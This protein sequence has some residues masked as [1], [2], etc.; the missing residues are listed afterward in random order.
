MGD[1]TLVAAHRGATSGAAADARPRRVGMRVA[2]VL[3]R[4]YKLLISPLFAGS[5]R[6]LPSCADYTA[7]AVERHGV[8][9]GSL[10]GAGRLCR[11]HPFG[12]SG[13][14]PVPVEKPWRR[15]AGVSVHRA[16]PGQ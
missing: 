13:H 10:L 16:G 8:L 6:Y 5:C 9:A 4:G 14:D 11:C 1:V 2:L 12:G 7:E 3:L 15:P